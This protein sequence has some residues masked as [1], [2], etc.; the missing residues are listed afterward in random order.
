M[1]VRNV[2]NRYLGVAVLAT[3]MLVASLRVL[4]VHARYETPNVRTVSIC[5]WQLEAGFREALDAL[6]HDYE[7]EYLARTGQRVRI[8]Q[9]PISSRGYQQFV[10]TG[11]IGGT[12]PDIIE[13]GKAKTTEKEEYLV[14]FYM[15]LGR[16]VNQP[17]PYNEGTPL[18]G[19]P[20]QD[21]FVDGLAGSYHRRLCDHYQI[22]FS[23]ATV[24]IFYNRDL[25][26]RTTGRTEPPQTYSE[27]LK[28]CGEIREYAAREG[29]AVE[30][31]AAGKEQLYPFSL[32]Y[33]LP[34]LFP[35]IPRMD[36]DLSG[37]VDPFEA[38][39]GYMKGEWSFRSPEILTAWRCLQE[40]TGQL[41]D[42][43]MAAQ[44]DD[45]V[46]MFAQERAVM[47]ATGCWDAKG[48]FNQA[49]DRFAVGVFDFPLPSDHPDYSEFVKG[50]AT[51]A[52]KR[53]NIPWVINLKT[54][55]PD[56]CVDFLRFCTT[57]DKN[58][59][60]N[61]AIAW[62]PVVRGSQMSPKLKAFKPRIQGFYG[63][64]S[65]YASAASRLI[66]TGDKWLLYSGDL[67]PEEYAD[68]LAEVYERTTADGYRDRMKREHIH[69]RNLQRPLAALQAAACVDAVDQH[70][71]N[72]KGWQILQSL[73]S[74]AFHVASNHGR[75]PDRGK[76]EATQ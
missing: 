43:W 41:Q 47:H 22:P 65:Y 1:S 50:P 51:E 13:R 23:L 57:T 7:V 11:L 73:Q 52:D 61:R 2:I 68:R 27:L 48:L 40:I 20:W 26:E 71:A 25:L 53:G 72:Q 58:A 45:A 69:H 16:Y 17:N 59:R 44:R 8:I 39:Q 75:F 19:I 33:E 70:V 28:V 66:G 24:R 62:I 56:L 10:N 49:G 46:F 3:A 67:S 18:E 36:A 9:V 4:I 14:R 54:R 60:F 42:G 76:A 35:L 29:V 74:R 32:G 5:H 34:F 30:P 38:Y 15:P 21:T 63:S 37:S 12:A 64:F 55:H 6:I 31:I